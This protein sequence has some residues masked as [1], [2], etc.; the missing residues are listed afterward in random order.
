MTFWIANPEILAE[1]VLITSTGHM[2]TSLRLAA[3]KFF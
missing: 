1:N 3:L 2:A